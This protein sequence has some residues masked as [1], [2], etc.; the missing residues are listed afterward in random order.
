LLRPTAV[1]VVP[2]ENYML[3]IVFDNGEIKK[4]DVKPYIK[5]KWYSE[6]MDVQYFAT[7]SVNGYSVEWAN[8]Q[9]LC[10]DELYYNGEIDD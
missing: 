1:K 10:P 5:G 2:L 7:V 4:F 8:G 6:L 3:R 9:D